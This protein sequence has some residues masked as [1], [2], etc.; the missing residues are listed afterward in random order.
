MPTKNNTDQIK[1]YFEQRLETHGTTPRGA[2][3]NSIDAQY[4]RFAQLAK[5]I[6]CKDAFTLLDYGCGY[7]AFADYLTS[8][9]F[10]VTRFYGFDILD[11]MITMAQEQHQD[12]DK[13]LFTT[14]LSAVPQIDYAVASGVFNIRLG[15]SYQQW[16]DFTLSCL[17]EI[18]EKTR[19]GFAV[20]FLTKYS[21]PHKM[22]SKLYYADPCFMFDHCKK[23]FSK[24]VSLLHD[25]NLYDFTIIVRKQ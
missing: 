20:N 15:S 21:D 13:Y 12:T 16:T 8:R 9:S 10:L 17:S 14:Q 2:D 11:S 6:T 24:N 7:G 23:H 3:W 1:H 5:V 22:S 4:T 19:K 25:Y 18:N